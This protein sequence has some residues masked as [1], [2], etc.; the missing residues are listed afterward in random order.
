MRLAD[1]KGDKA[2]E[3]LAD[4]LTPVTNLCSDDEFIEAINHTYIEGMQVALKK[5]QDD[6]KK[7]MA[8]LDLEDP[9]TYEI[10]LAKIPKKFMELVN[11]PDIRDLFMSQGQ[12]TEDSSGS[13]TESTQDKKE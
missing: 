9:E 8:V 3:V 12:E 7:M 11:D 10:T 4:L 6:V 5:H 2:F 1:I 13:A